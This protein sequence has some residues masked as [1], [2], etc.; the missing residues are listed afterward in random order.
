MSEY[1]A[2][3]PRFI[4][5]ALSN[6]SLTVFGTGLQ[7]RDFTYVKDVVQA[8]LCALGSHASGIFN[9][10]SGTRTSV[11]DL[12]R[13]IGRILDREL[14]M[15]HLEARAGDV[16]DSLADIA[17]ANRD[18]GYRSQYDIESGLRETIEWFMKGR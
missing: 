3:V 16:N 4:S 7:T 1:A 2:V 9:I 17:R 18:L 10:G 13:L 12:A 14:D 6:S 5:Q 8:N 11:I 15:A